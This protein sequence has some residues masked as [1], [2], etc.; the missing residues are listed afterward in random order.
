MAVNE[1]DL[2]VRSIP[3]VVVNAGR[4]LLRH[5][6]AFL[7]L[8][9]LGVAVRNA[10]LWGAVR[11]SDWNSFVA[12]LLLIFAPLGYLLPIIAMLHLCRESLPNAKA[13][14][15]TTGPEATT[16][17]RERRLIDVAA[18]V[19]VPFLAV[20]VSYGLLQSDRER[21]VNE[22][23][24]A[25]HNQFSLSDKIDYDYGG[26][27][28]I[29]PLQIVIL[30]VLAAWV[31]RWALGRVENRTKFLAWAFVGALVEV[32]YTTQV[33]R[34]TDG[35][36]SAGQE[37][38]EN[39]QAAHAVVSRYDAVVGHLGPLANPVDSATNWLFGLLGSVDA[40]IVVPIAW[41]TVGAVVLGHKLEPPEKPTKES[42]RWDRVPPRIR[43]VGGS[44]G[45]DIK[46]R[47]SAFW[48]GLRLLAS[49]G[50]MPMLLFCLVFLLVIRIPLG[51]LRA[52]AARRR[53]DRRVHLAGVLALGE[54][55]RARALD[56]A[57]RPAARCRP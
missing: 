44:L 22:A 34:K 31:L 21:F 13:L 14:A 6:P 57:D 41:L 4:L 19:L 53:S 23:A 42:S 5:W 30:I 3:G 16:E 7:V 43:A 20:Y 32:Y 45:G 10:A 56:G 12:Q 33:A 37:W 55:H 15:E 27:V 8:A 24:F 52:L 17:G 38:I 9:F 54:R 25:E 39:R 49:A 36:K 11:L 46:E 29:Y 28:G 18:S 50:L 47:W 2:G 26:R 51:R 40:I 1:L 35:L 48:N